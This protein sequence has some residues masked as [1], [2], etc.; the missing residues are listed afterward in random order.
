MNSEKL[1]FECFFYKNGRNVIGAY[2]IGQCVV[3][4]DVM[5]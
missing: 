2:F 3:R 1:E 4:G 5:G